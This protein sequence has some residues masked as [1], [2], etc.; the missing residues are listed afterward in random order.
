MVNFAV[1]G[2]G[3]IG[4]RHC[5]I[6]KS[7]PNAE[8]VAVCDIK[9]EKALYFSKKFE[10]PFF[11]DY[12]ELMKKKGIDV[13]CVCVPNGL[14]KEITIEA[15]KNKKHVLCEKPMALTIKDADEM[16]KECEKNKVQLFVVKQNRF[17]PPIA[18][19]KDA[20]ARGMLGKLYMINCSALWNRRNEYFEEEDWRG[21]KDMDGGAIFT[22]FSHFV[23]LIQWLGGPIK[24]VKANLFNFNHPNI[25]VEDTGVVIFRF[26]NGA[27]GILNYT[28]CVYNSNLEG[29]LTILGTKGSVKVG[30]QYVNKMDH[31]NVEGYPLDINNFEKCSPNIYASGYQGSSNNHDKVIKN[32]VDC[33]TGITK[34]VA[35][36][37]RDGRKSVEIIQAI[38]R[39]SELNEEVFLPLLD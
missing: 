28:T 27:T 35:T 8:L 5:T 4:D 11:L 37:G 3:K 17:N 26:E 13:I 33:L 32:V 6:I 34:E 20:I 38:F 19:V 22:Q 7:T 30:G 21:T 39:S 2:C 36:D 29:S 24:S 12:K 1:I 25:E 31:W 10:C 15:A 9:E 18:A 16:I 14:H 23:D